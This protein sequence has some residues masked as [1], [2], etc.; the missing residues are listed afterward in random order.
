ML[1]IWNGAGKYECQFEAKDPILKI[2]HLNA[3]KIPDDPKQPLSEEEKEE[4]RKK[5]VCGLKL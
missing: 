5:M 1:W 3:F 4:R 2:H